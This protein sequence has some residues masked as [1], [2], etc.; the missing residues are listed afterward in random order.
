MKRPGIKKQTGMSEN[1]VGGI[2][3]ESEGKES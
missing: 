1:L 3:L 2:T